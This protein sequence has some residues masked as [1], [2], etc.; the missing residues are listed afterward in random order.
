MAAEPRRARLL[1]AKAV[2]IGAAVFAGGLVATAVALPLA[3]HLMR[4]GGNFV[5]PVPLLT[6][7]RII[8]GCA[9]LLSLTAVLAYAIGALVRRG[10]A[11]VAAAVLLVV[12]PYLLATT[13]VLPVAVAG[14]LLRLT[15]AAAFAVQQALP[16]YPQVAKPYTPSDGYFPLP[17]WAGVLVLA[18][19]ALAVLGAAVART[20]RAD[21]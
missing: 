6:Q 13:S 5:L 8:A 2:V 20:R 14:W 4:S 1:A 7:L 19:W 3:V 10:V 16:A 9:A 17:A 18:A 21:A 12:V 11:A 15:P